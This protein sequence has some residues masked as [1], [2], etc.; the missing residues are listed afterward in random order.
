M[1]ELAPVR[2]RIAQLAQERDALSARV[3]ALTAA[4]EAYHAKFQV[5]ATCPDDDVDGHIREQMELH[6][7]MLRLA[8]GTP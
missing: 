3:A 1:D 5:V 8:R 4:I 7:V 6:A 2:L